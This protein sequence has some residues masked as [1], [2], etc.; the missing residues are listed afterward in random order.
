MFKRLNVLIIVLSLMFI[1]C[2]G[3]E[4]KDDV[5]TEYAIESAALLIGYELRDSFI[6]TDDAELYYG[7]IMSGMISLDGAK[8]AEEYLRTVT[9][10]DIANLLVNLAAM[11]GFDLDATG[12]IIG[13]DNV[14]SRLLKAA[15]G[16]FRL[17]LTL[18]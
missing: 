4:F 6:W 13:I 18:E 3:L 5:L 11:A 8:I 16:G 17:G 10:P 1:G 7:Y 15:A 2:A 12:N 9:H 14:N